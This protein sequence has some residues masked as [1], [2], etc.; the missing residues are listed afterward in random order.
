MIYI[1]IIFDNA[2]H[3]QTCFKFVKNVSIADPFL[4]RNGQ[5]ENL[6]KSRIAPLSF[7][8]ILW[9]HHCGSDWQFLIEQVICS[10]IVL[11]YTKAGQISNLEIRTQLAMILTTLREFPSHRVDFRSRPRITPKSAYS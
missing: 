1:C 8:I 5:G 3:A 9:R 6:F 4:L 11:S 7:I 10:V 2:S